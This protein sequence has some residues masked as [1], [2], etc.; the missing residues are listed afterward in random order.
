MPVFRIQDWTDAYS[1][2]PNIPDGDTWPEAWIEPAASFRNEQMNTAELYIRYGARDREV[3]DLFR[4]HGTAKG[5]LVFVHGGFWIRLDKSFWSHLAK[6]PLQRGWAVAIPSYPL[7]P[8]VRVSDISSSVAKS[9]EIAS[10]LID[11]PI[12]LTGHSAGGQIVTRLAAEGTSLSTTT[13]SRIRHILSIS[14]LHDLRPLLKTALNDTIHLDEQEADNE[15]AALLKPVTT[16]PLTCW[17][18]ANE[19]SEFVRQNALLG[20]IWRGLG[21]PTD[22]IEEPDRHHFNVING[23]GS[24]TSPMLCHLFDH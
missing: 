14:G 12:Y 10:Q 11:G 5:L 22:V 2:A 13:L 3:F 8:D 19:R 24:Q 15:S 17:V 21:V 4:P 1:N 9:I 20:N 6:G 7:C 18:G 16:C 23:L